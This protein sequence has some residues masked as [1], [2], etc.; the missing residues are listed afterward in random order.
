MVAIIL[1]TALTMTANP[2]FELKG[3]QTSSPPVIDGSIE[4]EAWQDAAIAD[5]FI[6]YEPRHGELSAAK[7]EAL[8]LYDSRHLYVAY[9]VWDSEPPT[10]QLTRRD[11]DLLNDDSV[12]LLLD[13]H[14]DQQSAYYFITNILGTQTDGRVVNDGRTV[15]ATWDA[16]WQSA[17]LRTEFGW[18][19]EMR[20]PLTSIKYT[21][22]EEITWGV[23]F[24]RSRRRTLE[25]S[26]WAGPLDNRF[27]VSQAGSIVGLDIP[28]PVRRH[29]II[30]FG[31]S[32]LQEDSPNEWDVG[33]DIRYALTPE[34]SAYATINPDFATIEADQ[35]EIN[36]TRFEVSLPEKRPFFLEGNELFRQR[37]RTFYSRRIPD[38]TAG[39]K[40]LGK[41]GAWTFAGIA[42]RSKPIA[43]SLTANYMVAR[44]Q[45]DVFGS[46]NIAVTVS[47]RYLKGENQGSGSL[48]ATLFFT[49]SFGMTTQLVKSFGPFSTGTWA[50]FIRPSYDSPTG[51]FHVRYTHLGDRFKDNANVIGFIRDD[52]RR[53]LDS[54]I[55]KTIWVR[56]GLI[57]RAE[58]DSNYN[59]YWGQTDTLR[60]WQIDQSLEF[61]LRNRLT[62]EVSHR[63]EFKRYEKDYRNRKTDF[64]IGYNTREF[65]SA[66][67]GYSFGRNFDADF[68]LWTVEAGCKVT[69]GLSLEY[70][71][72]RLNLNPD[73]EQE[74]TWIHVL[75]AN[76][77]FTKDLF[78]RMF[79]QTNSTID[80]K[81]LQAVFVYRY[82]PP[83]GTIQVAFQ[84]G[85]AEFGQRS[86]QGNTLFL[87]V[88]GVF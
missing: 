75:T 51:H 39:G 64:E 86:K 72:E 4:E 28:A 88:T 17:A 34:L 16:P 52:N 33:V 24:G 84:R 47:N 78:L 8:V 59:I 48:D 20:I 57:E 41:Q 80:R 46:S 69:S 19:V 25:V 11:A 68:H 50:Y 45:R 66:Q 61:E 1:F 60:S 62:V 2:L 83:F 37:I 18:T 71:L 87:K 65:Q 70:E 55:N 36:L 79:F 5:N 76:Q 32:H 31:L 35:E 7:T 82:K 6:Q 53:E 43:D 15:D 23:N 10:A 73:P 38:I 21:A 3:I 85:T 67:V 14:N 74:S 29:Q 27:R 77:F 13:T 26:F 58:Y 40:I 9:R 22:G 54:A 30:P 12:V 56:S 49:K 63:E 42:A 44:A 81:N